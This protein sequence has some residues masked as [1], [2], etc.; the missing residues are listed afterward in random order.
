MIQLCFGE[1]KEMGLALT[2]KRKSHK[3][4]QREVPRETEKIKEISGPSIFAQDYMRKALETNKKERKKVSSA[5]K[6]ARLDA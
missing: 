2:I 6:Q 1:I 3:R 4:S 5:E